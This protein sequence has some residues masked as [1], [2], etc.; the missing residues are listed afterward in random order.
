MSKEK[1][2]PQYK[3]ILAEIRHRISEESITQKDLGEKLGIKQSTVS[4]VLSGKSKLSLDL[5]L[6]IC[7][8]IGHRPQNVFR[9]VEVKE[10]RLV[11]PTPAMERVLVKSWIHVICYAAA[12]IETRVADI[13][14]NGISR[15]NLKQAFE[16][17]CEVELLK[18]TRS[19]YIQANPN[20]AVTPPDR[21]VTTKPHLDI[22]SK[23]ML[24]YDQ[25]RKDSNS[26]LPRFNLYHVD[27]FT[28]S[29]IKEIESSMWNVW[30]TIE[31][32]LIFNQSN[33][34]ST[35]ENQYLWNIHVMSLPALDH[36]HV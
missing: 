21:S 9:K 6:K 28:L 10:T 1:S 32:L 24:R 25:M 16:E 23:T 8:V 29:Q 33:S 15:E 7:D 2:H 19:G 22:I 31:R 30:N 20:L 34:Y 3:A 4:E 5:L 27:R 13:H 18:R 26:N 17:L 35:T 14:L 12:T 11:K 36:P